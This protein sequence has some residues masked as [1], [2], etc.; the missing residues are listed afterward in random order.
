MRCFSPSHNSSSYFL[1]ELQQCLKD[2]DWLA[3]LFIKH[4]RLGLNR[5]RRA[6]GESGFCGDGLSF[7]TTHPHF[8]QRDPC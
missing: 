4:V 3:Q 8:L 1:Q 2:P 5:G 7:V 6:W